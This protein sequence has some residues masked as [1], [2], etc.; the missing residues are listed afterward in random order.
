MEKLM[1]VEIE[2]SNRIDASKVKG[3]VRRIEVKEV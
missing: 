3:A 1:N 2:W